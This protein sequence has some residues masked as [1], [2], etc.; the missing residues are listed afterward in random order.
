[1]TA[2]SKSS[3]RPEKIDGIHSMRRKKPTLSETATA[4]LGRKGENA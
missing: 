3:L 2:F 4:K 1:M